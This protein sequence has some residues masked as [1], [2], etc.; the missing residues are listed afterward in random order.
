MRVAAA[1]EVVETE[2]AV[3]EAEG[4]AAA[5]NGGTGLGI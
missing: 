4:T 1:R 5:G 3:R 2:E